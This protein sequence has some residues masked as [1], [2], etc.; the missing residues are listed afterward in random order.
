MWIGD[1]RV[2][3]E[4]SRSE[5]KR[6]G[7]RSHSLQQTRNQ[8]GTVQRQSLGDAGLCVCHGLCSNCIRGETGVGQFVL[9]GSVEAVACTPRGVCVM[10]LARDRVV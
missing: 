9:V 6:D 3:E 1:D 4:G 7:A 2:R 5:M 8:G 10:L